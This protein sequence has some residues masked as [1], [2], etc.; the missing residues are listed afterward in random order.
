MAEELNILA[1]CEGVESQEQL[2]KLN[3]LGC[4]LFQGYHIGK[5]VLASQIE[6]LS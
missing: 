6:V 3:E 2:D 5:P 1:A 4:V